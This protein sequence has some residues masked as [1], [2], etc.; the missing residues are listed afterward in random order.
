LKT[1]DENMY[2]IGIGALAMGPEASESG[3]WADTDELRR[4]FRSMPI[5]CDSVQPGFFLEISG[6][7]DKSPH[8]SG[9]G[10]TFLYRDGD[11]RVNILVSMGLLG[12]PIRQRRRTFCRLLIMGS[13]KLA[14]RVRKKWPHYD[15]APFLIAVET[16]CNA[17]CDSPQST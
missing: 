2:V 13:E 15:V 14:D 17:L 7:F 10:R 9:V 5:E 12:M 8:E 4:L 6:R 16:A 3:F 1:L 11:C